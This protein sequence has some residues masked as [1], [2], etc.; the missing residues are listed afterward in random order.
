MSTGRIRT[1]AGG[2]VIFCAGF[3]S[4]EPITNLYN[5]RT[6]GCIVN[7]NDESY[8]VSADKHVDRK[9]LEVNWGMHRCEPLSLSLRGATPI[10][11]AE[12]SLRQ[13]EYTGIP[14]G[15]EWANASSGRP[16]VSNKPQPE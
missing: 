3:L 13:E 14:E 8:I 15:F 1:V 11:N 12:V 6:I 10:I 9:V 16:G 2:A 5:S 4:A 7:A